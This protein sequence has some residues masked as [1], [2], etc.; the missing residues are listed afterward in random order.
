M[1]WWGQ[2]ELGTKVSTSVLVLTRKMLARATCRPPPGWLGA[3]PQNPADVAH[4]RWAGLGVW[5]LGPVLAPPW[6]GP[7]LSL[8]KWSPG[9]AGLDG[10]HSPEFWH[11]QQLEPGGLWIP[12]PSPPHGAVPVSESS[13][14]A[15][16]S[17]LCGDGQ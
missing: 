4:V 9:H 2:R 17:V 5:T 3:W 7:S 11:Q 8:F 13:L 1:K 14:T 10:D 6:A 16:R 15:P 12:L